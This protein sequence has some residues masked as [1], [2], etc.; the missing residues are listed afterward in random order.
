MIK[1]ILRLFFYEEKAH[2]IQTFIHIIT[3]FQS[4]YG[5][6]EPSLDFANLVNINIHYPRLPMTRIC[7]FFIYMVLTL[8]LECNVH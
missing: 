1:S 6:A 7:H 2:L 8:I 5:R 3:K 4:T